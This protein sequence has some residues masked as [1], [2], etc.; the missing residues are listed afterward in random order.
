MHGLQQRRDDM[1]S[2]NGTKYM[3]ADDRFIAVEKRQPRITGDWTSSSIRGCRVP[4]TRTRPAAG[5]A[6]SG[7]KD[8]PDCYI[9]PSRSNGT[10]RHTAVRAEMQSFPPL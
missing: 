1:G 6:Y 10:R 2:Q 3:S 4:Q 9:Q 5:D 7:I 8:L